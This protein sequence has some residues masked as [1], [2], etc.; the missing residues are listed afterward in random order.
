[1]IDPITLTIAAIT[2]AGLVIACYALIAYYR[3]RIAMSASL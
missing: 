2:Y 3:V 1:M